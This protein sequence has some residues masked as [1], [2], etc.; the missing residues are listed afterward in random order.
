MAENRTRFCYK[1]EFSNMHWCFR[2]QTHCYSKPSHYKGTYSIVLLALVDADY[3]FTYIDIGAQGRAS[4]C[5]IFQESSL[6]A[7]IEGSRLNIPQKSVIVAD[8]AFPLKPYLMKPYSRRNLSPKQRIFN[9]RLSRAR[10]ISENAFGLLVAKFRIF[11]KPI[12]LSP[13]KSTSVS[14]A[15]I[16]LHNWLKKTAAT[17]YVT[18]G[19]VDIEDI[20]S[21]QIHLGSWR[22]RPSALETLQRQGSNNYSQNASTYHGS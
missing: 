20:E 2:W 16:A 17:S 8:D 5:G 1:V 19:L 9:Y 18:Q 14:K 15:A 4:D 11:E 21:G 13:E 7:A 22:N 10:R 3:C 6:Y 12:A